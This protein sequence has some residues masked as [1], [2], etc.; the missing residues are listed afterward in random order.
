MKHLTAA[1]IVELVGGGEVAG[2]EEHLRS[3]A[4]CRRMVEEWG[5]KLAALRELDRQALDPTE[6]HRLRVM[7]RQLGPQRSEGHS[8]VA[9]LLRRSDRQPAA[10][11]GGSSGVVS[12][13][14]AGP[15]TLL[16]RVGPENRR[17]RIA[18]HGQLS[19]RRG[20]AGDGTMALSAADGR[21]YVCDIDHFGEFHLDGVVPGRY[22]ALFW[23]Q[24]DAVE[25]ADLEIGDHD[26]G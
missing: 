26:A 14:E 23:L 12:E 11:R 18:V 7:Y 19:S 16:V 9:T 13:F 25:V 4:G 1:Q 21:A 3:C 15:Y 5:E 20:S 22:R 6:L 10:V 2:G 24:D 8:W 17:S